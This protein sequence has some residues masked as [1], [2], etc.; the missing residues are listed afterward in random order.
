MKNTALGKKKKK[1]KEH[2]AMGLVGIQIKIKFGPVS[3]NTLVFFSFGRHLV[4]LLI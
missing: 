3:R 2:M 4:S 1:Q